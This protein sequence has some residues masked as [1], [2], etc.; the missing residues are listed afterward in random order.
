V[1][2]KKIAMYGAATL[3]IVIAVGYIVNKRSAVITPG[4]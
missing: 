3:L 2:I 4:A 1:N